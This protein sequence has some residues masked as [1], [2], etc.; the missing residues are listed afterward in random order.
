[1]K[2]KP[3][4]CWHLGYIP[5][6]NIETTETTYGSEIALVYLSKIFT[7]KYRVIIFGPCLFNETIIDNIEYLN[8][9]KYEEFQ[10]NNEIE[11][12][13]LSR[14]I[15]PIL[16]YEL[17][18][19]KI[20]ILIQDVYLLPFY[21]S[22]SLPSDGKY[23]LK[24]FIDK[25]DGIV[26][27]TNWNKEKFVNHYDIDP[28]K[29]FIIGNAIETTKFKNKIKKQKNKFIWTSH[30]GR[31]I[32]KLLEY[33]HEVRKRIPDA[34]LY[35]Y[36][37]RTAFSEEALDEMEKY[38]YFHYGGKIHNDKIIEE[39][40]SSE[41]WFYPT[42]FTESCCISSLEAQ[43]SKCV[44]VS[45]YLGGLIET[46]NNRG[47]LIKDTIWSEKYKKNII[48]EV[49]TIM[50]DENLKEKYREAGYNWAKEQSWK[51]ISK[52]WFELFELFDKK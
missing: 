39:F 11:I 26:T 35:I 22:I 45:T 4:L 24:N 13:I 32:E 48:N 33:F 27:L 5:D 44:C 1:M 7:K 8:A 10:K 18:A 34:E 17:I 6:F 31:G 16:D 12:L 15:N 14:Y 9:D 38:D 2:N 51:N 42:N 29:V 50:N 25:I 20:F 41:M 37:D 49:V 28:N 30:G 40:Q 21:K 47:V 36:R 46:V 19:K 52:K 23:V 3:I 43:M